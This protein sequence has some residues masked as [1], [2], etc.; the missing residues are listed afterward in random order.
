[1]VAF[2]GGDR[3]AVVTGSWVG[4]CSI[5]QGRGGEEGRLFEEE[6]DVSVTHRRRVEDSVSG[7]NP[8]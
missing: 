3:V 7:Q 5:V 1:V 4:S 6:G 8:R 2:R